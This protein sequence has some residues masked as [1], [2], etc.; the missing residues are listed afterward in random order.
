VGVINDTGLMYLAINNKILLMEQ[1]EIVQD[2]LL[3]PKQEVIAGFT[4]FQ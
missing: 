2:F 4:Q 3:L 1:D